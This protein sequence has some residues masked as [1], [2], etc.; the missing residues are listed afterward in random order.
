[1]GITINSDKKWINLALGLARHAESIGEVPVGA[2]IVKDN[3]VIGEGWNQSITTHDPTA[4][5][6]IIALRSAA[7]TIENYRLSDS[8]LYVT[9]EP[10]PMCA[11][12]M[13][14]ARIKRIVYGASDPKT[15]AAGTIFNLL[16]HNNLNH[17][18]SCTGGVKAD[19]CSQLLSQFFKKRRDVKK[20]ASKNINPESSVQN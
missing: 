20:S 10:C 5:A 12:A 18:V 4:H 3:K 2:V 17:K 16:N 19:E 11:G 9:L 15:G 14:H 6:E 8:T 7:K 13:V 1:M